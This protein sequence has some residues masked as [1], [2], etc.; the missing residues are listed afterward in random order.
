M[1]LYALLWFAAPFVATALGS[2]A[3]IELLRV[4]CIAVII[5]GIACVPAGMLT[6]DFRQGARMAIDLMNF[7]VS[8]TVTMIWAVRG[9]GAMSFAWGSVAGN[10]SDW[11]P[12]R[13]R[14]GDAA[15]RL[16]PRDRPAS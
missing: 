8:T 2:A 3:A 4:L 14:A 12:R 9:V 11:W 15:L 6:R 13:S 7:V 5:D 10:R 1:A 16:E